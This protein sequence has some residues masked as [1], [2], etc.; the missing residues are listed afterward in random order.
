[1]RIAGLLAPSG[2]CQDLPGAHYLRLLGAEPVVVRAVRPLVELCHE[3]AVLAP[4]AAAAAVRDVLRRHGLAAHVV[5][6]GPER[7]ASVRE[8]LAAVGPSDLVLTHDVAR[9]LASR[10]LFARV[11]SEASDCG[12]AGCALP[13][14]STVVEVD[15]QGTV[16]RVA[17]TAPLH[18]TQS[19]QAFVTSL[20]QAGL[21]ALATTITH[22]AGAPPADELTAVQLAGALVRLVP[23]EEKN[24]VILSDEDFAWAEAALARS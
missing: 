5:A 17:S 7:W 23:G 20:L 21:D 19:P 3:V 16:V 14:P 11:L 2:W 15:G 6:A 13:L 4:P 10:A 8:A 1:M 12:A 22:P 9:P 24:R 18:L